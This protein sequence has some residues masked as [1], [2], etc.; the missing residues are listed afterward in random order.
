VPTVKLLL[1]TR[2]RGK[3]REMREL[4]ADV[5]NVELVSALDFPDVP[6]PEETGTTFAENASLKARWYAGHCDCLALADD[7]GL[8]VDALDGRPGVYSSRYGKSDADRISRLLG[9]LEEVPDDRRT[10]RFACAMALA[11]PDGIIATAEGTVEGRIARD[12]KGTNGFGYDP[13]FYTN[14]LECHLAE[15]DS[16]AKN[17]ISHRGRA[18][19]NL[20]SPLLEELRR[21]G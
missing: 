13:V 14:E 6:D 4:L 21:R 12:S 9:E 18:L 15:A 3:L 7:S 2:N 5:E 20:L 11:C 16:T 17:R 10:A 8:V 19:K 1:A